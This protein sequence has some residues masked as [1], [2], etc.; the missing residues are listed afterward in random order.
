MARFGAIGVNG[1]IAT[2][3]QEQ[4]SD[5]ENVWLVIHT[6]KANWKVNR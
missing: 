5:I 1:V 3:S 4:K 2:M 6:A